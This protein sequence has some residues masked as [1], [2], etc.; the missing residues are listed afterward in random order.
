MEVL[1]RVEAIWCDP[2]YLKGPYQPTVSPSWDLV[3]TPFFPN[4]FCILNHTPCVAS[5][6]FMHLWPPDTR[7]SV[8]GP[9]HRSLAAYF[10]AY[11]SS[12]HWFMTARSQ[13]GDVSLW[14]SGRV[15]PSSLYLV[16]PASPG[17][18]TQYKALCPLFIVGHCCDTVTFMY[19]VPYNEI[20]GG[21]S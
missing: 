1:L 8:R 9:A 2:F 3:E 19:P 21:H 4:H 12:C 11:F 5:N 15:P 20:K 10:T 7:A 14:L 13:R 17:N 18:V 6:L 16:S